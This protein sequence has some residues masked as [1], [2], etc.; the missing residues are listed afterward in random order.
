MK[1]KEVE[2]NTK[3]L[4]ASRLSELIK[5]IHTFG[6][7]I[8]A[9][10]EEKQAVIDEFNEEDRR[11]LVGKLSQRTVKTSIKKTKLEIKRLD[12]E[13]KEC[14][15]DAAKKLKEIEKLF[16]SQTPKKFRIGL[17]GIRELKGGK[18]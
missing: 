6:E 5:E 15:K 1:I 11:F 13:I 17:T 10:Q 2:A 8:R 18:K 4:D 9:K 12:K 14:I 16:K 3:K 7:L